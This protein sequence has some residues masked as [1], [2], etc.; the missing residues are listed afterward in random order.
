LAGF[1]CETN[2]VRKMSSRLR[3]SLRTRG[4]L[5]GL[6]PAATPKLRYVLHS[7]ADVGAR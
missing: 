1:G 2:S 7:V 3:L 4:G 5:Q 6:S